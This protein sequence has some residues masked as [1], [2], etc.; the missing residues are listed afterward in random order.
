MPGFKKTVTGNLCVVK[1][2]LPNNKAAGKTNHKFPQKPVRVSV[3]L[4]EVKSTVESCSNKIRPQ[5]PISALF[6]LLS[7]NC[8]F[9]TMPFPPLF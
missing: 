5:P 7:A 1:S 9:G 8:Q 6:K 4:T 2:I 3:I